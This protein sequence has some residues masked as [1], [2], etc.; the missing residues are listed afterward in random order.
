MDTA[1]H[2]QQARL[3]PWLRPWGP[4]LAGGLLAYTFGG[5]VGLIAACLF[6]FVVRLW[7][8]RN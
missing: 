3:K 6:V 8:R 5:P 1:D 7:N 2:E 4:L